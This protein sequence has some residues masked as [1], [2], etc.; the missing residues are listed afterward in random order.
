MKGL[1]FTHSLGL[2]GTYK[3]AY[4]GVGASVQAERGE[5]DKHL[6]IGVRLPYMRQSS[7]KLE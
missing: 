4:T 1:G 6:F 2:A 7:A 5:T 3:G